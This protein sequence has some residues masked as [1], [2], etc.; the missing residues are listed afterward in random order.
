MAN[1][2]QTA[3]KAAVL[4]YK[5]VAEGEGLGARGRRGELNP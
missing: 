3:L 5:A 1:H 4:M 2:N